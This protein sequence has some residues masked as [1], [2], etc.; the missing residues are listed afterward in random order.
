MKI[1]RVSEPC[2]HVSQGRTGQAQRRTG[3]A[4]AGADLS[5]IPAGNHG[6]NLRSAQK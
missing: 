3:A 1:Q 4:L 2:T 5:S 6:D